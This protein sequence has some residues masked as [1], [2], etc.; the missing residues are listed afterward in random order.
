MNKKN[1][2]KKSR[3][4]LPVLLCIV[5]MLSMFT[6]SAFAEET[7]CDIYGHQGGGSTFNGV[8]GECV[9]ECGVCDYEVRCYATQDGDIDMSDIECGTEVYFSYVD[10]Y[11][12]GADGDPIVA[13]CCYNCSCEN[14]HTMN[15]VWTLTPIVDTPETENKSIITSITTDLVGSIGVFLGGIGESLVTFFD[16][17]VTTTNAEGKRTLTTFAG[18]SIAFL[19]I[20]F[21]SMFIRK[22][23]K[24]AS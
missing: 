8:A 16:T 15:V 13:N 23:M 19:G 18:W 11:T 3:K 21:G 10:T 1:K 6:L 4:L 9:Y 17:V 14:G 12:G 7:E 2:T 5:L 22:L 24:K 20:G